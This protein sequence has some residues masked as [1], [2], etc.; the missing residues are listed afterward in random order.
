MAGLALFHSQNVS[1]CLLPIL[2]CPEAHCVACHLV[3]HA[4]YPALPALIAKRIVWVC[5]FLELPMK[6]VGQYCETERKQE[7][8]WSSHTAV[9]LNFTSCQHS[10]LILSKHEGYLTVAENVVMHVIKSIKFLYWSN[11]GISCNLKVS[12]SY[13]PSYAYMSSLTPT[14]R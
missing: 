11:C 7:I 6:V 12:Y 3:Q 9:Y 2:V 10:L 5:L 4:T 14:F 1:T 8:V 13:P